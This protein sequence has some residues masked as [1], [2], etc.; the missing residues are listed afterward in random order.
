MATG[1]SRENDLTEVEVRRH[2]DQACIWVARARVYQRRL[3]RW[4]IPVV[5]DDEHHDTWF[6]Q[7][8]LKRVPPFLQERGLHQIQNLT[9]LWS[10][11]FSG[12][13]CTWTFGARVH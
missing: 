13:R 7:E 10:E 1:R 12:G 2:G 5:S 8:F 9:E 3:I 4:V 11:H 6:V